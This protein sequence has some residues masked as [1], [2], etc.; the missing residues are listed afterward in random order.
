M[1]YPEYSE[2]KDLENIKEY[3]NRLGQQLDVARKQ[4]LLKFN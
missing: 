4:V 3:C 2:T 1:I